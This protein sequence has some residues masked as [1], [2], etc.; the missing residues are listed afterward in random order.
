[1]LTI[2]F[3][4][5]HPF[6]VE[7]IFV[8]FCQIFD[9]MFIFNILGDDIKNLNLVI[10]GHLVAWGTLLTLESHVSILVF[11]VLGEPHR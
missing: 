10:G 8:V 7:I 9:P 5:D 1:M 4:I 2:K 3:A 11:H 6:L